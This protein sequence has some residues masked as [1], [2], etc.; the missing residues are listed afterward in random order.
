MSKPF[1]LVKLRPDLM[2][3]K[4][5][6]MINHFIF[7]R[8]SFA[9][10]RFELEKRAGDVESDIKN[11]LYEIYVDHVV[12][13]CQQNFTSLLERLESKII[14]CRA[15]VRLKK[16]GGDERQLDSSELTQNEGSTLKSNREEVK[17]CLRVYHYCKDETWQHQQDSPSRIDRSL[18]E[19]RTKI[20]KVSAND[21]LFRKEI[22]ADKKRDVV[23]DNFS[24]E[25]ATCDKP[26]EGG[27]LILE[28][29][30]SNSSAAIVNCSSDSTKSNVK[31][32]KIIQVRFCDRYES[33]ATG[34][35]GHFSPQ[36]SCDIHRVETE[37]RNSQIRCKTLDGYLNVLSYWEGS[38]CEDRS[39]VKVE[40]N[41]QSSEARDVG[42]LRCYVK[43]TVKGQ[44]HKK[45]GL[46][47]TS[48]EKTGTEFEYAVV[49]EETSILDILENEIIDFNEQLERE[50]K[51]AETNLYHYMMINMGY[52]FLILKEKAKIIQA[53]KELK[54]LKV[55]WKDCK[56]IL[57]NE[58]LSPEAF[59]LRREKLEGR[60]D[61]HLFECQD[62]LEILRLQESIIMADVITER[63]RE[64]I[65]SGSR[66]INNLDQIIREKKHVL[67]AL[68]ECSCQETGFQLKYSKKTEDHCLEDKS[69]DHRQSYNGM[70]NENLD[71][72]K[73]R[74]TALKKIPFTFENEVNK[75]DNTSQERKKKY[76]TSCVIETDT[77]TA[78]TCLEANLLADNT[79]NETNKKVN[80]LTDLGKDMI[81]QDRIAAHEP[82]AASIH[83]LED[84]NSLDTKDKQK[85]A[86]ISKRN[87]LANSLSENSTSGYEI[88]GDSYLDY[89]CQRWIKILTIGSNLLRVPVEKYP[90]TTLT[91][92]RNGA[93]RALG[94]SKRG[95]S[96]S[97]VKDT[98]YQ[99]DIVE[100]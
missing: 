54:R 91:N 46:L 78:G 45:M 16:L 89:E 50:I 96:R 61:G 28:P 71:I 97:S 41:C 52:S 9:K 34:D 26:I 19:Q 68:E 51:Q 86:S 1:I 90:N 43:E 93:P 65:A 35:L 30:Q 7:N 18:T 23:K 62:N 33:E 20:N 12:L 5:I 81:N 95:K 66:L 49:S 3:F 47:E 59:E 70:S 87:N 11:T 80:L 17:N 82:K 6:I 2:E 29:T 40:K 55:F 14:D 69:C 98:I 25:T 94:R 64:Q 63:Q 37:F 67:R 57:R 92:Q 36:S 72:A 24:R 21:R 73:E 8:I 15:N 4:C 27:E 13:R 10:M 77:T 58:Q 56:D 42:Q 76:E 75:D 38:H 48:V 88:F 85:Q 53:E 74:N 60:L 22:K 32:K 31:A 100:V 44:K 79:I 84:Q 83:V 39:F 99:S